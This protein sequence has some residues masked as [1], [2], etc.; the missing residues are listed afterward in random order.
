[1]TDTHVLV[2]EDQEYLADLYAEWLSE[3]FTTSVAYDG[4]RALEIIDDD[5]DVVL[6]DRRMPGLS[7]QAVLE[8]IR[9]RELACSVAIVTAVE[10]DFDVIE[11][12]FDDYLTKDV[13]QQDL[14]E[15]VERL[16]TRSTYD[17]QVRNHLAMVGTKEILE[18]E[19]DPAEL[20][21]SERYARLE[22]KI[23]ESRQQLDARLAGDM[24]VEFLLDEVGE[25][26]HT[27]LQYDD[28]SWEY[29]YVSD[30]AESLFA[31][32]DTG[33]DELFTRFRQEGKRASELNSVFELNGYYC[34]L[35]LFDTIVLMHFYQ[36]HTEGI[37]CG[38]A[39]DAAS[40]LT[41]FV[42]IVLPYLRE[43]GLDELDTRPS[44]G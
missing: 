25:Y 30:T 32:V 18:E 13:S 5:I 21:A 42:A 38:F 1:M 14:K 31:G 44:W 19:K 29:R 6:L 27:V 4:T 7:G 35:H 16:V 9:S 17:E 33:L 3:S 8:E 24:L 26:L 36:P 15:T 34:S 11:M 23:A 28:D 37:V 22:E 2:V 12:G 43:A 20:A 41:D 40:N 39:P 10:P